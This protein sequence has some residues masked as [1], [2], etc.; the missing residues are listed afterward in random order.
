MNYKN[1]MN[2]ENGEVSQCLGC[3]YTV[4]IL[5]MLAAPMLLLL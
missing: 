4:S 3:T 5:G 2:Y 1:S